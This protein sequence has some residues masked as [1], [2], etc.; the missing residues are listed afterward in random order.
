M[1]KPTYKELAKALYELQDLIG[2]A[3]SLRERKVIQRANYKLF[4]ET[5]L[6]EVYTKWPSEKGV[7]GKAIEELQQ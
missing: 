3:L 5:M 6:E 4:R 2:V 7:I 1:T